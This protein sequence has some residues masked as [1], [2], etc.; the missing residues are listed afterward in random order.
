[1]KNAYVMTTSE[2]IK[3]LEKDGWY[4]VPGRSKKHKVFKHPNK[5]TLS[6]RP[7]IVSHGKKEVKLKTAKSILKDAGIK[8]RP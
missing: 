8:Y 1:M 3:I 6:G 4:P 2:I 5:V 7:L